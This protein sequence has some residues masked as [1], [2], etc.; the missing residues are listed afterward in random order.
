MLIPPGDI[1]LLWSIASCLKFNYQRTTYFQSLQ[2]TSVT[3][4][5]YQPRPGFLILSLQCFQL[6]CC[7]TTK[8]E[9]PISFAGEKWD[10]HK[11]AL[12]VSCWYKLSSFF[13]AIIFLNQHTWILLPS[14]NFTKYNG[15]QE[16]RVLS[17]EFPS[18]C[19]HV[20]VSG[21]I[22]SWKCWGGLFVNY[23]FYLSSPR[24][25]LIFRK[26]LMQDIQWNEV[27]ECRVL[28]CQG[29]EKARVISAQLVASR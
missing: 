13:L 18:V 25:L 17:E 29:R 26:V 28:P 7:L 2:G 4:M 22:L 9:D 8:G 5:D 20:C 16:Q 1:F 15:K 23:C 3:C 14:F 10:K 11:H 6:S 24:L 27:N 12:K 19:V 21:G